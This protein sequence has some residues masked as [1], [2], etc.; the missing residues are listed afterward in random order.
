MNV[1]HIDM[2]IA[3]IKGEIERSNALGFNMATFVTDRVNSRPDLS[4]HSQRDCGTVACIAGHAAFLSNKKR[5]VRSLLREHYKYLGIKEIVRRWLGL[6]QDDAVALFYVEE[7]RITLYK[8][9]VKQV[10][11]V[12][13]HLKA[14]GKVD[15]TIIGEI[16]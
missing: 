5:T 2:V 3:S 14:T 7:A 12:L 6:S 8:I 13:E 15:W 16:K 11:Q 4:D 10:I 9:I 1:A